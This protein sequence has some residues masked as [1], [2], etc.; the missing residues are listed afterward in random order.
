VG[1]DGKYQISVLFCPDCLIRDRRVFLALMA[2]V[3]RASPDIYIRVYICVYTY[4]YVCTGFKET[5]REE[6]ENLC[7]R[8]M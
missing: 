3:G 8:K 2:E 1:E 4:V 5:R 7:G 6:S